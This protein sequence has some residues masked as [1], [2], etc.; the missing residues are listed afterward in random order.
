MLALVAQ[1]LLRTICCCN[2]VADID[3]TTVIAAEGIQFVPTILTL[4]YADDTM[5]S[6][7]DHKVILQELMY[8]P[9][10]CL[11]VSVA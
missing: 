9:C 4:F 8:L 2:A 3:L 6:Y 10:V 11:E 1:Y 5:F 7:L